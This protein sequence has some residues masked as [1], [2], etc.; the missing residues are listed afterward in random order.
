MMQWSS[1]LKGSSRMVMNSLAVGE[2]FIE[3]FVHIIIT[4]LI[5]FAKQKKKKKPTGPLQPYPL[6]LLTIFCI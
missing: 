3:N 6:L 1:L 2:C 4:S 5:K